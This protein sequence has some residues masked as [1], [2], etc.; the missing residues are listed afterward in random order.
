MKVGFPHYSTKWNLLATAPALSR[1]HVDA[2]KFSTWIHIL[3]GAKLWSVI[4]GEVP[5]CHL[6]ELD[7]A[8]YKWK[9][10]LLEEDDL[11]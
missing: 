11:L 10:F 6:T 5:N 4:D 9:S 3:R 1:P 8:K 7:P 2:A